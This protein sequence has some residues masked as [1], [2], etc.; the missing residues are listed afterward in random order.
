[1]KRFFVLV[2]NPDGKNDKRLASLGTASKAF[3]RSLTEK[4]KE[5]QSCLGKQL[6]A[7]DWNTH[8]DYF[9]SVLTSPEAWGDAYTPAKMVSATLCTPAYR[10]EIV[11]HEYRKD[12]HFVAL[13][14]RTTGN[15]MHYVPLSGNFLRGLVKRYPSTDDWDGDPEYNERRG[16]ELIV[17]LTKLGLLVSEDFVGTN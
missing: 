9:K 10:A 15:P 17:E 3:I 4:V 11:A 14:D 7:F 2:K 12:M 16:N 13:I 6:T 1:M 5:E 8:F